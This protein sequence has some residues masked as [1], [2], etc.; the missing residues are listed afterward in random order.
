MRGGR[1]NF[2]INALFFVVLFVVFASEHENE[3]R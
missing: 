2:L 3:E 1:V